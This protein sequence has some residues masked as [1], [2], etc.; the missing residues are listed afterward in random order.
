MTVSQSDV[1][2]FVTLSADGEQMTLT[3][4]EERDLATP[5][6]VDETLVKINF[7]LRAI[8]TGLVAQVEGYREGLRFA[9]QY[10]VMEDPAGSPELLQ[11]LNAAAQKCAE[12]QIDF[13]I[14]HL[15]LWQASPQDAAM[16]E[17]TRYRPEDRPAE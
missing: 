10:N 11:F 15:N 1:I 5:G 7:Y 13:R 6:L 2:D 16:M 9:V 12:L 4:L 17:R 3:L 14:V 8:T